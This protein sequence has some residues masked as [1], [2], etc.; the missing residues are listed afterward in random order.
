MKKQLLKTSMVK[1]AVSV[2][3]VLVAVCLSFSACSKKKEEEKKLIE[4]ASVEGGYEFNYEEGWRVKYNGVDTVLSTTTVGGQLPEAIIRF[5]VFENKNYASAQAYWE[6]GAES[7]NSAYDSY[8]TLSR[9]A[10]TGDGFKDGYLAKMT[11]STADAVGV[12]GQATKEDEKIEYSLIQLV[13]NGGDRLCC[14]TYISTLAVSADFETT[15]D[16][17]KNTFGF[18]EPK[19]SEVTDK[20]Y[21]DFRITAPE[22]WVLTEAEAYLVYKKGNATVVANA[23]S[24]NY[25]KHSVLYWNDD[26]KPKLEKGIDGFTVVSTNENARLGLLSAVDCAYTGRSASG[27][28]YKFRTFLAVGVSDVYLLTLTA[29]PEDYDSCVGDF[30][31]MAEGFTVK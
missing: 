16:S 4:A 18:T 27:A 2:I 19:K 22:G 10:I 26:Y 31:K 11:V 7:F 15:M 25:S 24:L 21:A 23:F 14:A 17:V 6:D 20:G 12:S 9:E 13:F 30:L 5:T 29:S 3:L 28:E 1:K 8:K